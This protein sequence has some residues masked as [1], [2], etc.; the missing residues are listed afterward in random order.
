VKRPQALFLLV[1]VLVATIGVYLNT[2]SEFS[3][4]YASSSI[5]VD[6]VGFDWSYPTCHALDYGKDLVE[7]T[8]HWADSRDV[9]AW[10]YAVD[11]NYVYLRLDFLD[12]AYGAETGSYGSISD[13]LNIYIL[14]GWSNAPG[15]QEWVPDYVKYQGYGIHLPDYRWVVAIAIYDTRNYRVYRYDWSVLLQNTGLLVA[16]NS[17]WDLLEVAVPVSILQSYG[18][19][20]T[21]RVWAKIATVIVVNGESRVSDVVPNTIYISGGVARWSG[22]VFSDQFCGTAKVAFV[23][24]GNQHLTDN[25]ALNNPG[26]VNSYGYILYVHEYLTNRTGRVIPVDIHLSGT[27]LTSFLWWDPGFI[28]YIRRLLSRGIV[29]ILGGVWAEHITAYFYDNFNA[30]SAYIAKWQIQ[31]VFGYTPR[32]AW[33]PERTWDDE[34]TGIAWTIS[35]HYRAVILDGNTHHDD[36][37]GDGNH[38][39]PH[40]YDTRRTNGNI[41]YVFFID[42]DTQQKL[43]D[44]TDGGLHR[45]L[46]LKYIWAATNPDQQMVFIYAEDWEKAAGIAGWDQSNPYR[47]NASLTWIAMRPWIQVV[48]LEW[49]VDWLNGGYWAPVAGYYCG[50]D[51]YLYIKQW[52]DA[53]PYDYRRAYDGWYWGTSVEKSFAWYGSGQTSPNYRLPDTVM[54]FGDVF[55]YT[56][57]NGSPNNT[58]IYRLLAPGNLFDRAPK[59]EI[60]WLAVVAASAYLFETAWHENFDWDGDGLHD[61][62]GWGL[63]QWN[64]LRHV[65]VLLIAARWLDDVRAGRVTRAGYIVDDVDWDGRREVIIYNPHLFVWIDDKGGAAPFVFLYNRTVNRAYMVVGAPMVYWGTL[66]D[67]WFGDSQVGLFADDYFTATRRNYYNEVYTIGAVYYDTTY[68]R[69]VVRLNAPDLDRDGYPDFYKYFIL[70]DTTPELHIYYLGVRRTGTLYVATGFS[71]DVWTSLI[72]GD[73]MAAYGSPTST[74]T[75]GYRNTVSRVY[76]YITPV[77][78]TAWTG[79]QDVVKYTLQYRAKLSVTIS[80]TTSAYARVVFGRR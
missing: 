56:S 5:R 18:W 40:L 76:V 25:R 4:A 65:N 20:P 64:H 9:L 62:P 13:A 45:D 17:Q 38:Y 29:S 42:W 54:P 77:R 67:M 49:V 6:G 51:T 55:G 79:S 71:P 60:W 10:Y 52:V 26:S 47:Y 80:T 68:K 33:I 27:L 35:K 58:I 22:A 37:E 28:G 41:L 70:Y 12:L 61:P 8:P 78:N 1:C 21:T 14:L 66:Y 7:S 19:T 34:R 48:S 72:Y 74:N 50:Y 32:I 63:Q 69:V 57:F 44:N 53:Y 2:R 46:R 15:Y 75:F 30:P 59:N 3:T 31:Q 43:L 16:F 73:R 11:S 36:W 24:H 23:H 39:K